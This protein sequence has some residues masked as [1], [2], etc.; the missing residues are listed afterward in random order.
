M[1]HEVKDFIDG[2]PT[3]EKPYG[4]LMREYSDLLTSCK[5]GEGVETI[6]HDSKSCISKKQNGWLHCK[7]GPIMYLV[8]EGW[9][10]YEAKR[11]LK[12]K[13]GRKIF[14]REMTDKNCMNAKGVFFWECQIASCRK[15]IFP[16]QIMHNA[17]LNQKVCPH[18]SQSKT[19]PIILKSINQ[20][21]PSRIKA[22]NEAIWEAYPAIKRPDPEW[23]K[24]HDPPELT[25]TKG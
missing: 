5:R 21:A 18:C 17:M 14:V 8:G 15:L 22:W 16:W 1:I 4:Q 19:M 12:V 3:Y 2:Q 23:F 24:K 25:E 7:D 20:V 10:F 13:F 11:F 9:D 6:K